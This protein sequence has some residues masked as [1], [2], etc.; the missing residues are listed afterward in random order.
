[1]NARM[2]N[3]KIENASLSRRT[4]LAAGGSLVVSFSLGAH[5]QTPTA[6]ATPGATPS[7]PLAPRTP[8]LP[9]SLQQSPALD[10]WIR[11]DSAGHVTIFTGKA[12]L[13]QGVRTAL[14]QVAA[15]QLALAP[16]RVTLVTADTARTP[17]EGFTAGSHS[18]QDSGTAIFNAAGQVRDLLVQQAATLLAVPP[19]QLTVSDGNVRAPDGRSLGFGPLAAALSLH[20]P[21]HPATGLGDPKSYRVIG[22]S[23]PRVD[24]PAKVA[25]GPAYIQDMRLP[26]M[27]H[28]RAIRQP[29]PGATLGTTDF[30]AIEKMPGVVK[31]LR[32]GDYLAVVAEREW[33]AVKA[34]RAL[35]AAAEWTETATLPDQSTIA[36][37]IRALPARDIEILTWNADTAPPVKRLRARYT[38]PYLMHGSIGPSCALAQLGE[39]GAMT[40]WTHTQGVYPQ[41]GALA[42]LLRLPPDKLRCIHV[43]GSGC[44]GHNGADD[45]AAD[46]ALI[47]RAL[48]GRPI[49]VQWMRDQ[50]H[51]AE[52]FGPAMVAEIDGALDSQGNIVDWNY[53][54]WSNTHN[55]R[56]V[57]GGL[58]L[59]NAAL[60]DHLPVPPPAPIPM[61]EGGGE[62]N[63]NPLYAFPNAHVVSHFIAD[64]PLRV[65]AQRSLGAYHNIFAIESFM[66][67]LAEAASIDPVQ[68]RLRHMKDER[69]RTVIQTAAD[70]FAWSAPAPTQAGH[71]RGFAFARYKNLGAYCAI[72]MDLT[73]EHETG[74]IQIGRVVAAVDSGQPINPDG[75]RN[76]IEG[77]IMQSASWTLYEQVAFDRQHITSADWS[78][79]PILRFNAAP[80]SI[81]VHIVDRPGQ[82]FL[83]TGEAGQGPTAAAIANAVKN[84]TGVRLRDLPLRAPRVKAAIGV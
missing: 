51:T 62:R 9:G 39:D 16:A 69:A 5:A 22:I 29:S 45:V 19:D 71:G 8:T 79:Y 13:G 65:S 82:P 74:R 36:D 49:R 17:D 83:G 44:Y 21:A 77:A 73:V 40:V 66:D 27:L 26:G 56:P 64:M 55:M 12:E 72:A 59:Q 11:I 78:A 43:E 53:G 33:Q 41:R 57:K 50:E 32:D 48:P 63:S 58:F 34:S 23:L 76:Q 24:I 68:F 20:Q 60:P 1:M 10:A 30:T 18:M 38:K 37:T 14:T 67:E 81:D 6:N 61:P 31:I 7:T 15:E 52:P 25:G 2:P 75:I 4:L 80:A 35:A 42:E 54:V 46:A 84:A 70:K 47:A 28:A 3:K